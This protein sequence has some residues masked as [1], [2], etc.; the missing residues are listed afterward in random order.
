MFAQIASL[1]VYHDELLGSQLESGLMLERFLL[2]DHSQ[3]A[4]RSS[5]EC[6]L[7]MRDG[8][9][10]SFWNHAHGTLQGWL[11]LSA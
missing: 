5:F 1:L 2:R 11:S 6:G 4:F 7:E 3:H 9:Q 8:S 10:A